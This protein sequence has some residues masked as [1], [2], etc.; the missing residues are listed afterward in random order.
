MGR[1]MEKYYIK[2]RDLRLKEED[3]LQWGIRRIYNY[4][5]DMDFMNHMDMKAW[6]GGLKMS[7]EEVVLIE[8]AVKFVEGVPL[9]VSTGIVFRSVEMS[10]IFYMK[11]LKSYH[12]SKGFFTLLN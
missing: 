2:T 11:N 5:S 8:S 6:S 3:A 1:L 10:N 4:T 9:Y 7:G 12:D